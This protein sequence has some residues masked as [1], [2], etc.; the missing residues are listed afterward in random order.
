M[1]SITRMLFI[2]RIF[3]TNFIHNFET[4]LRLLELKQIKSKQ[5]RIMTK[6]KEP[7]FT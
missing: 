6:R 5:K 4:N 2:P 1:E 7:C 3:A